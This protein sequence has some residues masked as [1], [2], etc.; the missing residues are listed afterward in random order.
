MEGRKEGRR[1][2]DGW[3][4]FGTEGRGGGVQNDVL[5]SLLAIQCTNAADGRRRGEKDVSNVIP[6][7]VAAVRALEVERHAFGGA[8]GHVHGLSVL[9][10]GTLDVGGAGSRRIRSI[11]LRS[12]P[13]PRSPRRPRQLVPSAR[14]LPLFHV[15]FTTPWIA[16]VSS[17]FLSSCPSR[18]SKTTVFS[19][20]VWENSFR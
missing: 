8:F 14:P 2:C 4:G 13:T 15:L 17:F 3:R 6:P 12:K 20:S 18:T 11:V 19:A 1:T 10:L 9:A 7:F 16:S 5:P